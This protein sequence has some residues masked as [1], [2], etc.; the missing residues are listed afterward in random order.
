MLAVFSLKSLN[1]SPNWA[2]YLIGGPISLS[3]LSLVSAA[4][5]MACITR[6]F[7]FLASSIFAGLDSGSF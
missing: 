1:R 7:L 2:V 3:I 6:A 4:S 5:L